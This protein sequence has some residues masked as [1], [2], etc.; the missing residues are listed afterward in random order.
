MV[1]WCGNRFNKAIRTDSFNKQRVRAQN[2]TYF[3]NYNCGGFALGT[4][5][6]YCPYDINVVDYAFNRGYITAFEREDILRQLTEDE[7]AIAK[8]DWD[9]YES[10]E[11][12]ADYEEWRNSG[13]GFLLEE[14]YP[15]FNKDSD[16]FFYYIKVML[17]EIKGLRLIGSLDDLR[18]NEYCVA[19]R[20]GHGD[21]HYIRSNNNKCDVWIGKVGRSVVRK[22]TPSA[23]KDNLEKFFD[24]LFDDR[25]DSKTI[26]FAKTN[27]TCRRCGVKKVA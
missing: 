8:E 23:S 3:R 15:I 1:V 14:K 5:S 18:E 4:F 11:E 12:Y 16:L 6:W 21:F 26:L 25:Y 2:N 13:A 24:T 10:D 17:K 22:L 9:S 20:V 7:Y 27:D 19:F